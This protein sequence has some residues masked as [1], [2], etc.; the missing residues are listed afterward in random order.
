M[1][2]LFEI[3]KEVVTNQIRA[4]KQNIEV[5]SKIADLNVMRKHPFSGEIQ[6][7]VLVLTP[8]EKSEK[9]IK[10]ISNNFLG[11]LKNKPLEIK[12]M[13]VLEI[14]RYI[15]RFSLYRTQSFIDNPAFIMMIYQYLKIT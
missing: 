1:L 15:Y 11:Y 10:K 2:N 5:I 4:K 6:N 7:D 12:K 8:E 14:Y 13:R 3:N 9:V